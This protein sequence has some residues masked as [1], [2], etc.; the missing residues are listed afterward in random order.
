MTEYFTNPNKR[1]KLCEG[2]EVTTVEDNGETTTS[3]QVIEG[4]Y[5]C[6]DREE[7]GRNIEAE[8]TTIDFYTNGKIE[9]CRF[10]RPVMELEDERW[11]HDT[12]QETE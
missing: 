6:I 11:K 3:L 4:E 10:G 12:N 1:C 2:R 7:C 9:I 8:N 5:Y